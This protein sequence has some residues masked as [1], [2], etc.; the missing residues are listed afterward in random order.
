MTFEEIYSCFYNPAIRFVRSYV[1]DRDVAEDIVSESLLVLWKKYDRK[2]SSEVMPFF[3]T[4]LKNKALDHLKAE[5]RHMTDN[6]SAEDWRK[7]E[8][9]LRIQSLSESAES[10]VFTS[11]IETI[12]SKTL[13]ALPAETACIF[14]ESRSLGKSYAEI[15]QNHGMTEKGVEYHVMRSLKALRLALVDYL[16]D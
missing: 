7:G 8:L 6:L 14:K 5:R 15:A 9:D 12:V 11:E 10:Q 13:D 4:I 3:Y 1:R 2:R 16:H